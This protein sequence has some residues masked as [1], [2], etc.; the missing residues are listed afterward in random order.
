MCMILKRT[1]TLILLICLMFI[2][3]ILKIVINGFIEKC[4]LSVFNLYIK[5]LL[6][7]D[8]KEIAANIDF[9]YHS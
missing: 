9:T 7:H 8:L 6:C 3:I 5:N 4:T 2:G 1:F